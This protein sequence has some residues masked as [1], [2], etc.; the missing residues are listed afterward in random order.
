MTAAFGGQ[1]FR[2]V[3][4]LSLRSPKAG[5]HVATGGLP[6]PMTAAPPTG[7]SLQWI[8]RKSASSS[9]SLNEVFK[10]AGVV[11]VAHY[12]GLTVAQMHDAAQA[13]EAGGRRGEGREE[14]SRQ[15]RS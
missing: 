6:S 2:V 9:T 14:P 12:A 8:E 13:D 1:A 10:T 15:D 5:R 3:V 11:V 4:L 7:E